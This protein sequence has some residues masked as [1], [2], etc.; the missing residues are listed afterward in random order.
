MISKVAYLRDG[1]FLPEVYA[2]PH[3][4]SHRNKPISRLLLSW[5]K[6]AAPDPSELSLQGQT[7]YSGCRKAAVRALDV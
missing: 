5:S 4:L 6:N 2:R 7:S 1:Y 3:A